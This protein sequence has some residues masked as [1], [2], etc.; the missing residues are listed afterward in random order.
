[1]ECEQTG[2]EFHQFKRSMS[3]ACVYGVNIVFLFKS[4]S[5]VIVRKL[6]VN[7]I[8]YRSNNTITAWLEKLYMTEKY[9]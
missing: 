5:F 3:V 2:G 6:N 9:H 4:S 1:M 8:I 7:S